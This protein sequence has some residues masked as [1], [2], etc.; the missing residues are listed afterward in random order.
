M[1][2]VNIW[3]MITNQLIYVFIREKLVYVV[4]YIFIKLYSDRVFFSR[5]RIFDEMILQ[6]ISKLSAMLGSSHY[7][8]LFTAHRLPRAFHVIALV[9]MS[10]LTLPGLLNSNVLY[11]ENR[12]DNICH[13]LQNDTLLT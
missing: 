12:S 2:Y 6:T 3:K 8:K 13:G 4:T 5:A 10:K 1:V 9:A 11:R 7:V